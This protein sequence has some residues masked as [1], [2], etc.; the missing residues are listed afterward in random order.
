MKI[1]FEV[2]NI[3]DYIER[4]FVTVD[5]KVK[6]V[7]KIYSKGD[8]MIVVMKN[9]KKYETREVRFVSGDELVPAHLFCFNDLRIDNNVTNPL[10]SSGETTL[11][12]T[13][14]MDC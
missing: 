10:P 12:W 4:R 1:S 11:A 6:K 7:E 8:I 9:G 13:R 3:Y 2:E 5:E 14:R